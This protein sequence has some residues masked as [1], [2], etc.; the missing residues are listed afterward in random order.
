V[1]FVDIRRYGLQRRHHGL[2]AFQDDESLPGEQRPDF[3]L[4][5]MATALSPSPC[6]TSTT[7]RDPGSSLGGYLSYCLGG[8]GR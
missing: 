8:H 4:P 5:L 3:T 6:S 7:F 2:G 1:E